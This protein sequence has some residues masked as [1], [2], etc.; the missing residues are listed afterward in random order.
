MTDSTHTSALPPFSTEAEEYVIGSVLTS[1]PVVFPSLRD[2]LSPR[3]FF[4]LHHR[5][6]WQAFDRMAERGALTEGGM[7]FVIEELRAMGEFDESGQDARKI[8]FGDM[9]R[10]IGVVGNSHDAAPFARHVHKLSLRREM[11][12][13]ADTIRQD[14]LNENMSV[15]SG[16]ARLDRSAVEL[17]RENGLANASLVNMDAFTSDLLEMTVEN[18]AR[19]K[20]NPNYVVG[21]RTGLSDLDLMLD[22][23]QP[24]ITTLAAATGLGK[25]GLALQIARY[26]AQF[27]ILRSGTAPAKVHFFSGEMTQRM[28][29]VRMLSS[30]TGVP[31]RHIQRG[32]YDA[33][34]KGLIE[35]ALVELDRNT[36]LT[37]EPGARVNTA[38]L[39]QR[40]RSM[41]MDNAL[42]LLVLDG[43]LQIEAVR[44]DP[45]D[46]LQRQSYVKQQR[47]DLIEEIMNELES[48]TLT[49]KIPILMTHQ[50]SRAP[51]GR[52][53][54]RPV[55][56]DLAEASFV[57]HKSSV[58]LFLYRDGYYT[59]NAL[60]NSA[61]I[62]CQKNRFGGDGTVKTIYDAQYTRFLDTERFDFGDVI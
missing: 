6:F 37:L 32:S 18:E 10:L 38:Q 41:V 15:E 5:I 9:I 16:L 34:Q 1:G 25:T 39:R 13:A 59:R 42:D 30:M 19:F 53:D 40:V 52:A 11:L 60:D 43:L 27:G 48:L 29:G 20:A 24:G 28:L 35:D 36:M 44:V 8:S 2:I 56:T 12:A 33:R 50:I 4:K 47:R 46:S 23:L 51:S 17:Q 45:R 3:H 61:E 26:A 22:G 31:G 62:I 7:T 54:K 21:I 57:D 55:I 14:A 58:I 49:Y